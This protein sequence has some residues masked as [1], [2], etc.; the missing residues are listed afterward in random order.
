ME[1][2]TY[3]CTVKDKVSTPVTDIFSEEVMS[4]Q[5]SDDWHNFRAGKEDGRDLWPAGAFGASDAAA[6][7]D[8]GYGGKNFNKLLLELSGFKKLP[9][10]SSW[11]GI[12]RG[13]ETEDTARSVAES[14]LNV[15]FSPLCA[16][17]LNN[18]VQRVSYDGVSFDENGYVTSHV[19]IKVP[20]V[21]TYEK[22]L[23]E[24]LPS[25]ANNPEDLGSY[26]YY[27]PQI[28]L[29]LSLLPNLS[30]G[31]LFIFSQEKNSFILIKVNRSQEYIDSMLE[32]LNLLHTQVFDLVNGNVDEEDAEVMNRLF[33]VKELKDRAYQEHS[34]LDKEYKSLLKDDLEDSFGDNDVISN[35]KV[36][37]SKQYSSRINYKE[38]VETFLAERIAN[39]EI[40][41]NEFMSE[42]TR[43]TV[44]GSTLKE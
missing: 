33:A 10:K 4:F 38:I 40:D 17:N 20:L 19:E 22:L 32:R 30:F 21:E 16:M 43:Y 41:L 9:K 1:I 29:Q 36:S 11:K 15:R 13:N 24:N 44:A 42:S 31:N 25:V 39:G 12:R 28:Q 3:F 6:L 34:K 14:V 35:G 37:V 8:I 5:G 7:M 27:Y 18:P 26:S 23:S 2:Q